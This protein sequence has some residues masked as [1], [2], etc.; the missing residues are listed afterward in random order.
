ML[1]R[2]NEI[3]AGLNFWHRLLTSGVVWRLWVHNIQCRRDL[4]ALAFTSKDYVSSVIGATIRVDDLRVGGVDN[5]HRNSLQSTV[6]N[7]LCV[8]KRDLLDDGRLIQAG[9]RGRGTGIL[10]KEDLITGRMP[11]VPVRLYLVGDKLSLNLPSHCLVE[12][13][14]RCRGRN[15]GQGR[16]R[17]NDIVELLV[18]DVE[19]LGEKGIF[20]NAWPDEQLF[21]R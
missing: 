19:R 18:I 5:S 21:K 7:L 8:C 3:S 1:R 10:D 9:T 6:S 11:M 20:C 14:I 15:L 4:V 17:A 13:G 16:V 2:A 12:D